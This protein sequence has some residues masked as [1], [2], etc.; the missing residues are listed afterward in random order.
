MAEEIISSP[1]GPIR[2]LASERG[3]SG[4]YLNE[5]KLSQNTITPFNSRA[6]SEIL[7]LTKSE[8]K[9]YF[10][11]KLKR[12][13]VPLDLQGTLFQ[14]SV[15]EALQEIPYGTTCSYKDIAKKIKNPKA[16]RA[17]GTANAKN[18]VCIIIPCHRVVANNGTLG[19]Y[20][21][22]PHNKKLLL[23]LENSLT[24]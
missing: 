11:G 20:S 13:S 16:F 9:E 21:S 23:K 17:V 18:P 2:I 14:I 7:S 10:L 12:F 24:N 4:I 1:L 6:A 8:L 5:T 22:G 19:G 15:W 3:L